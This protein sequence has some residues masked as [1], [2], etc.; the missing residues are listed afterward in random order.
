MHRADGSRKCAMLPSARDHPPW[1]PRSAHRDRDSGES[2]CAR[3][4][5]APQ[6]VEQW[7][8]EIDYFHQLNDHM[9]IFF[10]TLGA[11]GGDGE[12]DNAQYGANFDLFL[13][14]RPVFGG[15]FGAASL[16]E[17]RYRPALLRVGYRYSETVNGPSNG[18]VQ[19]R[20]L[21]E[22]SIN[23]RFGRVRCHRP[24]RIR[25]ALDRRRLVHAISEPH[26]RRVH[27]GLRPLFGHA[28]RE[29]RMVLLHRSSRIGPQ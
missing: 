21:A 11:F 24:E 18:Q 4:S 20:I 26:L 16:V 15:V 17:D 12:A 3:R 2:G 13:K 9:R 27:G 23:R 5:V 28:I 1:R 19:N 8:P 7:W 6:T 10:Q 29:Q 14:A 22:F 25:L